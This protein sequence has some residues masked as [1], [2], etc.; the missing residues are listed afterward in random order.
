MFY[1]ESMI[2]SVLKCQHCNQKYDRYDQPRI[3]PCGKTI[4][5]NCVIKIQNQSISNRFKC[6]ICTSDHYIP[7]QG[8]TINELA[9]NLMLLQPK[10]IYRSEQCETLKSNLRLLNDLVDELNFDINNGI[11]KIKYHCN[12]LRRLVQLATEE[13]IQQIQNFNETF[14]K[15]INSYEKERID[16]YSTNDRFKQ[17]LIDVINETN[18]FLDEKKNY[19]SQ[20]QISEEEIQTSNEKALALK[21]NI[22]NELRKTRIRIFNDIL[23]EFEKNDTKLDEKLLGSINLKGINLNFTV[24]FTF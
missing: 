13:R 22:D 7:E 23:M 19:L 3:I 2:A 1:E 8:F 9:F 6:D 10:E 17:E 14:L 24:S 12:E 5:N 16:D 18:V 11:D 4:C 20:C 21:S 15:Q